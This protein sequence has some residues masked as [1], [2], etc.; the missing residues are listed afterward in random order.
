M[1]VTEQSIGRTQ[2]TAPGKRPVSGEPAAPVK[3]VL[4][5]APF[6]T[7]NLGVSALASGTVAALH[8]A[9]EGAEIR[10][11]DYGR[12][13][14][15]SRARRGEETVPIETINL[16]FSKKPWQ[17]NHVARLL[18]QA[19]VLRLLPLPRL[20]GWMTRKNPWLR[21]IC[22]ARFHLAIAGGDSFSD[23]YGMRRL[24]YMT[25]PQI[26]VLW[27]GKP[28][29]LLPQTYGPFKSR[30]ARGVARYIL[31]RARLI[32]SRD[33]AG[34]K[35]VG[36]LLGQADH[37]ARF[38]Y[39]MG[40]ALEPLPPGGDVS[41]RLGDLKARGCLIGLNVSGLLYMGGYRR[42]NMFG[43]KSDYAALVRET[44]ELFITK[45]SHDVLLVPHVLGA[46]EASESDVPACRRIWAEL[47]DKYR[48]RLHYFEG[49]FDQHE[50]KYIIGQC[51][52]FLGSRMHA[53]IAALSQSVP[54][55]GMAYSRKF[56]GVL[57]SIGGSATVVDLRALDLG[58][59]ARAIEQA[60]DRRQV[61]RGELE[62]RMPGIKQSVLNLF[63]APEFEEI[64]TE[65]APA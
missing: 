27:L 28:L 44:L 59:V 54:T 49:T 52:F 20:R 40:F 51:D 17:S 42:N 32:Y 22:E 60:F 24:F 65:S 21:D 4:S 2:V 47:N 33:Q 35:V 19:A 62:A 29:V 63:A 31:R 18:A 53:C 16:R 58:G 50:I 48:G 14:K 10:F 41:R 13:P 56:A 8:H 36:E 37:R 25:L 3:L 15:I 45:L 64:L 61:L 26:L 5:G 6:N 7:G 46:E 39:D 57:D 9:F 43:L 55:V 12:E 23:I 30:A 38:A 11:L 1:Q 34:L